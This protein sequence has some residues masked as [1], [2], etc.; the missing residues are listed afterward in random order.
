VD[1]VTWARNP[2]V[3]R[4][5]ES[6]SVVGTGTYHRALKLPITA[7]RRVCLA[8]H[9][10][11]AR[12]KYE[13]SLGPGPFLEWLDARGEKPLLHDGVFFA[14]AATY[15]HFLVDG[16][17]LL[18][19]VTDAPRNLYVDEDVSDAQLEFVRQFAHAAGFPEFKGVAR[20]RAGAYEVRNGAFFC[21]QRMSQR[22]AWIRSTLRI[23]GAAAPP[24]GGRRLFVL[25]NNAAT[26][27]LLNQD[28]VAALA[29]RRFGFEPIDPSTLSPLQQAMAFRDASVV[30]G[31]HGAGLANLIFAERPGMLVEL[32][33]S[34]ERLFFHSLCYTLDAFHLAIAGTPAGPEAARADNADYV[35]DEEAVTR[36]LEHHLAQPRRG[37]QGPPPPA[38]P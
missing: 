38:A 18:R 22:I 12:D 6:V 7:D 34:V 8:R 17:G 24:A 9:Q 15:W 31:P 27:R 26:R 32:F 35:V 13:A 28:R 5:E 1:P 14:G 33:H 16:L 2:N 30:M 11:L 23:G 25:R 4:A 19:P 3:T 29:Q 20:L 10:V 21:R 37:Y 36:A